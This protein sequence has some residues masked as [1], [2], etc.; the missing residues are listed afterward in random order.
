MITKLQI[1]LFSGAK[2]KDEAKFLRQESQSKYRYNLQ[3]N[4]NVMTLLCASLSNA[5]WC[6]V[7]APNRCADRITNTMLKGHF[8]VGEWTRAFKVR[9]KRDAVLN[10][11]KMETDT[12]S[13]KFLSHS[14][15]RTIMML[16]LL[17]MTPVGKRFLLKLNS[18]DF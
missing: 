15:W 7:I 16:E 12:F 1:D 6:L 2:A 18:K 9:D 14:Y 11:T 13:C 17:C 5:I 10:L 4:M 3:V 8:W